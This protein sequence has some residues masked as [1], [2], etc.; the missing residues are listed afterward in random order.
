MQTE[1]VPFHSK[2][3]PNKVTAFP[4]F[5]AHGGLL[6]AYERSLRD[7]LAEK[8]IVLALSAGDPEKRDAYSI[9]LKADML[10]LNTSTCERLDL[11]YSKTTGKVSQALLW[12][13]RNGKLR[14][15]FVNQGSEMLPA[16]GRNRRGADKDKLLGEVA[17]SFFKCASLT[18][19]SPTVS[20]GTEGLLGKAAAAERRAAA[21]LS[22]S[23]CRR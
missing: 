5:R 18:A 22:S 4:L 16:S 23:L 14:G 13:I 1:M 9:N 11:E 6:V 21:L 10:G 20:G 15:V 7:F 2:D 8:K 17:N 3:F 19:L 12:A